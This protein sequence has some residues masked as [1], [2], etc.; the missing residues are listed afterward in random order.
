[1]HE[2]HQSGKVTDSLLFASRYGR[3][4][5]LILLA[6]T[7]S[8]VAYLLLFLRWHGNTNIWESLYIVPGGFGMGVVQSAAFVSIQ[9]SVSPST[10]A[11]ATSVLYLSVSVGTIFGLASVGA[12][13]T[14]TMKWRLASSLDE[15]G[16]G[17]SLKREVRN[18]GCL[19]ARRPPF[20][21]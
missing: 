12:I 13:V 15:L 8:S 4:K 6:T 21:Y 19:A 16:F 10:K 3:Y 1:M 2:P 5:Y 14:E 7:C 18:A 11:A 17:D 9:A 20:A